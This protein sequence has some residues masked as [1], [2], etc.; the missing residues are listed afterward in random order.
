MPKASGGTSS[1]TLDQEMIALFLILMTM[2]FTK[3]TVPTDNPVFRPLPQQEIE[4]LEKQR[5]F[6]VQ[7][8]AKHFP[9]D[10]L[11]DS[12]QTIAILQK[13]VDSAIIGKEMTWELQSLG[14]VFGDALIG[15]IPGLA[16]MEVTDSYGTDPALIYKDTTLQLNPLT[17]ISKRIEDAREVDLLDLTEALREYVDREG[18]QA[19]KR[20]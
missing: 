18:P 14:V 9:D 11:S 16:W 15:A 12:K 19:D 5:A 2:P 4:R 13:I 8:A 6:V 20:K 7:L 1:G 10:R 3:Q 17:M